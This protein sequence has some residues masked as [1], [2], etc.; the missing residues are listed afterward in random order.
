MGTYEGSVPFIVD[1]KCTFNADGTMDFDNNVKIQHQEIKCPKVPITVNGNTITFPNIQKTGDCMGDAL[2]GQ[3]KD[4]TKFSIGINSDG[5]LT[6]HSTWPDLKL[7][8]VSEE[9]AL[10][11]KPSGKYEGSVPFIVDISVNFNADGTMDFDNNVKIQHLE[12]KCAK[13]AVTV[14]DT[15]VTFPNIQKTGDCMGDALRGQ[16][17]DVSKFSIGINSDGT[18]TFHSTWPD[19]K[20]KKASELAAPAAALSGKYEG[21]VPLI[22]DITVNFNA[23]G[24]MDFDNNVKIQHLEVK[25]QKVAITVT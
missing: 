24:T 11:A 3:K 25:C 23:D 7:K 5:T 15:T 14:T 9:L 18:L 6:F 20:L 1:I 12:V 19:L 8:K 4:V 17:K 22:V 2:R 10:A 21:S 16:K 13:V